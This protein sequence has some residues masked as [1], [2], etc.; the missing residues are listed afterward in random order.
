MTIQRCMSCT[1]VEIKELEEEL[2]I[3][4]KNTEKERERTHTTKMYQKNAKT[5]RR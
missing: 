3:Y 4:W 2:N 1:V 5:K